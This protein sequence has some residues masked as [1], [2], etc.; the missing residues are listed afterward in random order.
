MVAEYYT[1]ALAELQE[2]GGMV[3]RSHV[4]MTAGRGWEIVVGLEIGYGSL[5]LQDAALFTWS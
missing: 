4:S 2:L 3:V 1:R 5:S